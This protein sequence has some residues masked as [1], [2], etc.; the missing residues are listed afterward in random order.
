[1]NPLCQQ[2]LASDYELKHRKKNEDSRRQRF[3][4]HLELLE[5]I[6]PKWK[7]KKR[8][9]IDETLQNA[10][11][12]DNSWKRVEMCIALGEKGL[13]PDKAYSKACKKYPLP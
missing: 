3:S 7:D 9:E 1:M 12:D 5:K 4:K 11:Y 2:D 10:P 13:S 8:Y 6:D